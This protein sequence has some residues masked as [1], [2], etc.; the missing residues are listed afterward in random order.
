[1]QKGCD[2]IP[3]EDWWRLSRIKLVLE[4]GHHGGAIKDLQT[5]FQQGKILLHLQVQSL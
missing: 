2:K 1:M 5:P 4:G 3:H